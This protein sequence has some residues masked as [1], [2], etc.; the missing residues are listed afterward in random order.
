MIYA[1]HGLQGQF[2][3]QICCNGLTRASAAFFLVD[4]SCG[5]EVLHATLADIY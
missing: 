2:Y 5:A 3:E 1:V 4:N